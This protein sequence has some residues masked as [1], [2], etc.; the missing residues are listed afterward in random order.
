[1]TAQIKALIALAIFAAGLA[2]GWAVNGWRAGAEL[3]HVRQQHA[4]V[5]QGIADK[6][7]QTVLAVQ[8]AAQAANA[9]IQQADQAANERIINAKAETDRLRACVAAGTCG[10]RIVTRYVRESSSGGAADSGPGSLGDAAIELDQA[11]GLRVLDL[12]ESIQLD[13]EKLEYLQRYAE[14]CHRVGLEAV[15]VVKEVR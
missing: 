7:A 11:A 4:K 14:A 6:T 8:K 15:K 2:V 10:V 9:A 1:M 12:R 3:A 5:L 13:A